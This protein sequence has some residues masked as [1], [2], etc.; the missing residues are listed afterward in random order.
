ML[1]RR[2]PGLGQALSAKQIANKVLRLDPRKPADV[3]LFTSKAAN[4]AQGLYPAGSAM[5][6]ASGPVLSEQQVRSRLKMFLKGH[7]RNDAGKVN[8][9]L[10]VFDNPDTK[11]LIPDPQPPGAAVV[12]MK[13]I[14]ILADHQPRPEQ[15]PLRVG[16][17]RHTAG[18]EWGRRDRPVAPEAGS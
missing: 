8:A 7:F 11:S 12:G 17:L 16:S 1:H 13:G 5:A 6:P 4:R 18:S 15:W 3:D 14:L 9:A 10:A 2:D